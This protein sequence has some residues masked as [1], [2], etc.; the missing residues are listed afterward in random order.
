MLDIVCHARLFIRKGKAMVERALRWI[1]VATLSTGLPLRIAVHEFRGAPGGPTVGITAAIHGDELA[2]VEVA[3]AGGA[4]ER[5]EVRGTV[6][7]ALAV[8]PLVPVRRRATPQDMTNLNRVFPGD[9]NGW[10]G[11]TGGQVRRRV[12]A[13]LD[14]A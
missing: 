7:I 12:P 10:L 11:A 9:P 6:R 13:G 14:A 5:A 3:P 4:P 1:D 8:N 2:P